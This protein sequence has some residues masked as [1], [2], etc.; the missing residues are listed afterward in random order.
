[1][2]RG[3]KPLTH[4][5]CPWCGIKKPR[6]DYF[7][8]LTSISHKCKPCTLEEIRKRQTLYYGRYE[9]QHNAWRRRRYAKDPAFRDRIATQKSERYE[10]LKEGINE[11]RRLRWATDPLNPARKHN[12]NHNVQQRSP[13]WADQDAIMEF[14]WNC[15]DGF[16]VDHIIPLRGIIDGRKVTGLHVHHNLQY[17]TKQE[18]RRKH[19]R[20]SES[21]I[22]A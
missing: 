14:Y 7:K 20:I 19:C 4:K 22:P 15:P 8:K 12:R 5:V 18:N 3:P 2:K 9:E 16:E 1:M 6:A 17:L 21:D 13:Q 10:R 11:A